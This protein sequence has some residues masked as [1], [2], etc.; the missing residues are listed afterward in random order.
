M[1]R[2][3]QI[4][5]GLF[6]FGTVGSRVY[7]TLEKN[8][9]LI[10][11][12]LG[13]PVQVKKIC[14]VDTKKKFPVHVPP[15]LLTPKASE[16]LDDPEISIIVELIGDRPI[17]REVMM[18]A[19][20]L[21]KHVVTANKAILAV[22]GPELY[23][24]AAKHEVDIL[25]EASVAG[26]IPVLRAI[27]EG[28]V[29]DQIRSIFGII[30]GTANTILSGMTEQKKA[31]EDVLV[32]AQKNGYAEAD[33][34]A[35]ILGLDTAHKLTI[36]AAMAY[37]QIVPL[38]KI[39]TEGITHLQPLDIEMASKFGYVIKL[40]AISKKQNDEIEARVHPTMIP[41]THM[42]ASA[43]GAF[44]AVMVEGEFLGRSML[45][46]LG[47]GGA[48][49]ATAVVADIIEIARNIA[50]R[51]PGV[52]PLGYRIEH[53]QKAKVKPIEEIECEYYLRF[54]TLDKP[55]VLG[56]IASALGQNHIGIASVYQ[57]GR[58]EGKEV[59]IVILVHRAKEKNMINA[60]KEI[61][62]LSVVTQK[63]QMIRIDS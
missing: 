42:L 48:P 37:G 46:G 33:P 7:E 20:S 18:N 26:A 4:N 40:L 62:K 44:N 35:D 17:A 5:I 57:H 19:M 36:L 11:E 22:H 45:Y 47:A 38:D 41:V 34:T 24:Q 25:F 54:T 51:V 30:N 43:T 52:P 9:E 3:P 27:R 23:A 60:L 29:A 2:I 32:E 61:D 50:L 49:T 21:G 14:E 8:K 55:G 10:I 63:T 12:K 16:V 58:E 28:F 15:S 53:M 59:P 39:Y 31:F 13:F 6:G 56:K 1:P